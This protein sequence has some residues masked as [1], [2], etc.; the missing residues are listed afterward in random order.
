MNQK[1]LSPSPLTLSGQKRAALSLIFLLLPIIFSC[2]AKLTVTT[3]GKG[4]KSTPSPSPSSTTSDPI[5]IT[6]VT[7]TH[8][9]GS[10]KNGATIPITIQFSDI[11][12]VQGKPTLLLKTSADAKTGIPYQSGS[13]T[14]ELTFLYSVQPQ[15]R[16]TKLDYTSASALQSNGASITTTAGQTPSLMLATPGVAGSLSANKSLII[17]NDEPS[18]SNLESIHILPGQSSSAINFE[19]FDATSP[20]TCT[21]ANLSMT[22]SNTNV[23]S[24]QSVTWGGTYPYCTAVIQAQPS[25]KGTSIVTFTLNDPAGA[26][27]SMDFPA[28]V[29][30]AKVY[31]QENLVTD[32]TYYTPLLTYNMV[33][34]EKRVYAAGKSK[35]MV[36]NGLPSATNQKPDFV[37]GSFS[38]RSQYSPPNDLSYAISV[39]IRV[40]SD[41]VNLIVSDTYNNRV[42]IW[43]KAPTTARVPPDIV[44]GQSSFQNVAANRGASASND[45]L[46]QPKN[47]I[48]IGSKLFVADTGN[49]RVLVWNTIPKSSGVGAD[50]VIGQPDFATTS[51]AT[52]NVKLKAPNGFVSDGNNLLVN[53]SGNFRILIWN[54]LPLQNFQPADAVIG[55]TNF[56]SATLS[57][58]SLSTVSNSTQGALAIFNNKLLIGDRARILVFDAV[59]STNF[60][61]AAYALGQSSG[62]GMAYSQGTPWSF[63]ET[64]GISVIDNSLVITEG[65]LSANNAISI[66]NTLPATYNTNFNFT[67][68]SISYLTQTN[69]SVPLKF[70]TDGTR[71]F[72]LTGTAIYIWNTIPAETSTAPNIVLGQADFTSTTANA[73]GLSS[74]SLNGASDLTIVAG[75]LVV[76]DTNNNRILIWN[77]I[78]TANNQA[79]DVVVGQSNFTS[80]Q[81]NRGAT[82]A[83][84]TL[85][86]PLGVATDGTKLFISDTYNY[87][88]LIYNTVPASNGASA[89]TV[90]G[91]ANMTS[92]TSAVTQS[93]FNGADR[94]IVMGSSLIVN[95]KVS[96]RIMIWNTVPTTNGVA[97]DIVLG[98]SS[99]TGSSINAGGISA[100]SLASQSDIFSDGSKIYVADTSNNRIL[101]WNTVPTTSNQPADGVYGQSSFTSSSPNGFGY[102]YSPFDFKGVKSGS[103]INNRMYLVETYRAMATEMP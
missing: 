77:S 49:N 27:T 4:G 88:V 23:V 41:G 29:A 20:L 62:T 69:W 78:P 58:S 22:S 72:A 100:S 16:S 15:D 25:S 32:S 60:A 95:E 56:D 28:F 12:F 61:S 33:K 70:H 48:V 92:R 71:L 19:I 47:A 96:N 50:L 89:N 54:T 40:A 18:I 44:L 1:H 87:R 5:K 51:F 83:A 65:T 3:N 21:S 43:N 17:D 86:L 67:I 35:I 46:N 93:N 64:N 91:Q 59:P 102:G 94:L 74:S 55:Q 36:W 9:N 75:K 85:D 73:G 79:A 84:N 76:A 53:D 30:N 57:S 14:K 80:N 8:A 39:N 42:L 24:N 99:F 11:V 6:S 7:S 68:S 81:Q 66:W 103:F 52:S 31:G 10:Y 97:A 37:L 26:S 38:T 90:I 101:Y 34:V 98:Q 13:G 2:E 63:N 45:T 82:V